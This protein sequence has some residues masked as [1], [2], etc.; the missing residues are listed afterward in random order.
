MSSKAIVSA[1]QE[2][3]EKVSSKYNLD[4]DELIALWEQTKKISKGKGK[5]IEAKPEKGKKKE[6][7]VD[8]ETEVNAFDPLKASSYLRNELQLFCKQQGLKCSGTKVELIERLGGSSSSSSSSPPAPKKKASSKKILEKNDKKAESIIKKL[9]DKTEEEVTQ[10]HIVENEYGNF[11]HPE[12]GF[13]FNEKTRKVIGKQVGNEI[14]PLT[15]ADI[16]TC[17]NPLYDFRYDIPST[18]DG[19]LV[20]GGELLEDDVLS[21]GEEEME[22]EEED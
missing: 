18:I 5:E 22:E 14:K 17:N 8:T 15:A 10:H 13:V 19:N 7:E 3:A 4:K 6:A 2:F 9:N 11:V 1:I 16:V 20:L 12:T 21:D